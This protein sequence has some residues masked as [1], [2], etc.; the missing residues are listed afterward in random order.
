MDAPADF[1]RVE[2]QV[3][4]VAEVSATDT[5]MTDAID[6]ASVI[7]PQDPQITGLTARLPELALHQYGTIDL[8][9]K[10]PKTMSD[11]DRSPFGTSCKSGLTA[12]PVSGAMVE[13]TV[14]APCLPNTRVE[15]RHGRM[16]V[17]Q[18]TSHTGDLVVII[19]ALETK[20]RFAVDF[21]SN[22]VLR[23]TVT[24]SGLDKIER[25]AI[26]WRGDIE[27]DLHALEFGADIGSTGHVWEGQAR[28]IDQATRF[29]VDTPLNLAMLRSTIPSGPR[30]TAYRLVVKPKRAL[31]NW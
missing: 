18:K 17:T 16:V 7:L 9:F 21:G 5:T 26:Q 31:L 28:A 1:G 2:T 22:R 8:G 6:P 25:T 23:T 4:E 24:V 29:G 30:F 27:V 11:L 10:A 15:I 13:L 20:A 3:R 19:P 14:N 12:K